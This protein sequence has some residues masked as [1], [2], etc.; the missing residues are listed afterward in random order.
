MLCT[1]TYTILTYVHCTIH[2][3]YTDEVPSL[4]LSD[5]LLLLRKA[6]TQ[7]DANSIDTLIRSIHASHYNHTINRYMRLWEVKRQVRIYYKF[8]YAVYICMCIIVCYCIV[9]H[10]AL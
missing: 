6:D 7:Q 10:R 5:L 3:S 2:Y 8:V 4:L 9:Y 1:Y